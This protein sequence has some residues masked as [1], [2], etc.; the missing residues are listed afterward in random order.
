MVTLGGLPLLAVF[1]V[2]TGPARTTHLNV[3]FIPIQNVLMA[4][5]SVVSTLH[6]VHTSCCKRLALELQHAQLSASGSYL[7]CL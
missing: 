4:G 5:A 7:W 1:V 6:G 2:A 3:N